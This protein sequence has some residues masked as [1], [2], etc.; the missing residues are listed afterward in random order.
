MSMWHLKER[1]MLSQAVTG[2]KITAT[3]ITLEG[4]TVLVGTQ[5]ERC[6]IF[7]LFDEIQEEWQ[8]KHMT[9]LNVR[10]ARQRNALGKMIC[11]F[12]FFGK[13]DRVLISSNGNRL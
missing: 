10:S 7:A 13:G 12:R 9:Q 5:H 6:T 11:G 4:T 1:K 3:S 8:F 2:D